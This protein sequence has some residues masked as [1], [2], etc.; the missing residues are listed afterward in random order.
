[1]LLAR[2]AAR[3][4]GAGN[5]RVEAPYLTGWCSWYQYFTDITEATYLDNVARASDWPFDVL[6]L[7]DGFQAAIGD[8]LEP[9]PSFPHGLPAIAERVAA[10]GRRAGVWL[11]PFLVAPNARLAADRPD[12]IARTEDGRHPLRAWWNPDW[13]GG[14]DGFLH[15]LDTT[16]PAVADHLERLAR[17]VVAMGFDYL[18]LDFTFAPSVDG[19]WHDPTRT[20]A[21][22]VRAG[23][24]AVR[25]GAGDDATLVG[26]GVPLGAVVGMIDACRIGQ[27]VAPRWALDA[28]DEIVPGY[29]GIQPAT[30]HAYVNTLTRS[31]MHRRLW[32]NDPD[33]VML[34][35]TATDLSP[36][37]A[38]A[39]AR[40][41]GLSGGLALVSDDLALLGDDARATFEATTSL[42]RASDEAARAG[43]PAVVADLLDAAAPR[44]LRGAGHE[45]VTD[46]DTGRSTL[47]PVTTDDDRGA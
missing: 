19:R 2:W 40:A 41:V 22:R 43:R 34:R 44:H 3:V 24:D 6:Q 8:W 13:H 10:A 1:M 11:A 4:G 35:T 36:E 18:K 25:R 47:T 29:L 38:T 42:G 15:A 21:E 16:N 26:C 9:D 12:W 17:E 27:D 32:Q 31:F 37:A 30:R 20:P 14:D 28:T 33:C 7:D 46:P 39:W 45:L 23:F 5:A